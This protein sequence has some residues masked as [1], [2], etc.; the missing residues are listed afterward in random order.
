M[1]D[2]ISTKLTNY[3]LVTIIDS[4]R[5]RGRTWDNIDDV[6]GV[7]KGRTRRVYKSVCN[8]LGIKDVHYYR[9]AQSY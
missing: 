2:N 6:F 1:I 7:P 3:E 9:H 5:Y 4:L 8:K